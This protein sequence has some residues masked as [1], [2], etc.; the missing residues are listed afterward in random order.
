MMMRTTSL[1]AQGA[2]RLAGV[3]TLSTSLPAGAKVGV[4]GLGESSCGLGM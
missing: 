4:V 1:L 3:R 2:A